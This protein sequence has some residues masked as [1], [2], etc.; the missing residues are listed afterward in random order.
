[1][2]TETLS[3]PGLTLELEERT[4]ETII[5]LSGTITA[6]SAEIF[7]AEIQGRLVADSRGKFVLD[8]GKVTSVTAAGSPRYWLCGPRANAGTAVS[9]SPT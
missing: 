7:Q 6:E 1:M 9:R 2:I 3:A 4:A 5:H 8:L